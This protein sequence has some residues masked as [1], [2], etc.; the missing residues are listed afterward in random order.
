MTISKLSS[1]YGDAEHLGLLSKMLQVSLVAYMSGGIF[2]N[3]AHFDLPWHIVAIALI[4]DRISKQLFVE[5]QAESGERVPQTL[6]S[7]LGKAGVSMSN[8][9]A[10]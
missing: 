9:Y 6:R 4:L 5:G 3:L 2:L 8:R 10:P 7:N 1:K